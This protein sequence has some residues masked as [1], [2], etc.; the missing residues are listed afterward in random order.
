MYESHKFQNFEFPTR[1]HQNLKIM[2]LEVLNSY[3]LFSNYKS[4]A[5][6]S[7]LQYQILKE[8]HA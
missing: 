2:D 7:N 5:S 1:P 6:T 4:F 3:I 8:N